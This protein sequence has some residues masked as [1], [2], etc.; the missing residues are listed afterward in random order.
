MYRKPFVIPATQDVS[1]LQK[2]G[3]RGTECQHKPK[4]ASF[5]KVSRIINH[6]ASRW[7]NRSL[8]NLFT[9]Q[10]C[11]PASPVRPEPGQGKSV[12]KLRPEVP[13]MIPAAMVATVAGRV[14]KACSRTEGGKEPHTIGAEEGER[15]SPGYQE[16]V[17]LR[18][19]VV[20]H[21]FIGACHGKKMQ[22]VCFCCGFLRSCFT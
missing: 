14:L 13:S 17:K 3:C 15:N 6:D 21:G 20:L 5:L 10:T 12:K 1:P 22:K 16:H 9:C 7:S 18:N 2:N 8:F 19:K 4:A 11:F